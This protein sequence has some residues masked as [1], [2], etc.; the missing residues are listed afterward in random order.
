M[1][2][3]HL[4]RAHVALEAQAF[5]E[6]NVEL[7]SRFAVD[8]WRVHAEE[9]D[10]VAAVARARAA[11]EE[12]EVGRLNAARQA[13]QGE[14]GAGPRIK[15]LA[16]RWAEAAAENASAEVAVAQAQGEVKRLRTLAAAHGL[17]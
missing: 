7:G 13:A 17:E 11:A 16:R 9:M 12:A 2:R 4:A 15:A 8:A 14:G 10:G 3:E 1:W 5:R 6:L